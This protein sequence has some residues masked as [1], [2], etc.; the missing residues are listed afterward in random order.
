MARRDYDNDFPSVTQ[1]LDGLRKIGLEN[2]FKFTPLKQ[3]QEESNKGKEIGIQ[4]H[5]VIHTYITTNQAKIKTEYPDEVMNVLKGFMLFRKER[6]EYTLIGSEMPMI[7]L[8]Y[9]FN[10]TMDCMGKKD[11]NFIGFDWKSGKAKEKDK[12]DIYDEHKYQVAAYSK[13]YE[14]VEKKEVK[15]AGIL[16]LAKDKIAYNFY[17]MSKEEIDFYFNEIFLHALAICKAKK[18]KFNK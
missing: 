9:K 15:G 6:P 8:I 11:N 3:I 10:G 18:V 13:L 5:E 17:E 1:V 14:E 12:P 2:W 7:S 4:I 16:A